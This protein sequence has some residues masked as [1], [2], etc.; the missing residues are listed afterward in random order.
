MDLD[1]LNTGLLQ[2]VLGVESIQFLKMV[3]NKRIYFRDY[4]FVFSI[5]W[6][7]SGQPICFFYKIEPKRKET[8]KKTV[9]VTCFNFAVIKF[10]F[11]KKATKIDEIFT[12]DLT[13]VT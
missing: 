9:K 13:L 7:K 12:I 4:V 10:V 1:F 3:G 5:L 8:K 11:S 2:K 6:Q